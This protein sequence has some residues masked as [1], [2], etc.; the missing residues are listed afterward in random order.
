MPT[1]RLAVFLDTETTSFDPRT[2]EIIEL[3]IVLFSFDAHNGEVLGIEE[4]YC[5]LREPTVRIHPEASAVNGITLGM[6]AGKA[7]DLDK[8][9]GLLA[10][11]EVILA[12]N[13]EFDRPFVEGFLGPLD[14]PWGCSLRDVNWNALGHG[15]R[16]LASLMQAY[17]IPPQ[18]TP[19]RADAD[20][21]G[22]LALLS[23]KDAQGRAFLAQVLAAIQHRQSL[24]PKET[25]QERTYLK[26]SFAQ[27]DAVKALGARWDPERKQWFVPPGPNLTPFKAWMTQL[28]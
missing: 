15:N 11:A 6:V 9:Q 28:P 8:V 14:Q 1:P 25:S 22:G 16:A 17:N 5:G 26:V 19:H 23:Q 10:R 24:G 27:K 18:G 2:E 12:H 21:L 20:A 13:A 4:T 7:L 3:A